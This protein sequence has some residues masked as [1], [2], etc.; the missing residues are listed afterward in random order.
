MEN[1]SGL[2]SVTIQVSFTESRLEELEKSLL[3]KWVDVIIAQVE[4]WRAYNVEAKIS[5]DRDIGHSRSDRV[6]EVRRRPFMLVPDELAKST[7]VSYE[8]GELE[9]TNRQTATVNQKLGRI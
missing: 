9:L 2:K 4:S 6:V 5:I 1:F 8:D 7:D 3:P